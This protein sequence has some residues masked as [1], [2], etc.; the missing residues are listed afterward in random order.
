MFSFLCLFVY[1]EVKKDSRKTSVYA[2][3]KEIKFQV[4]GYFL[5]ISNKVIIIIQCDKDVCFVGLSSNEKMFTTKKIWGIFSTFLERFF[6][7]KEISS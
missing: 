1:K 7:D 6:F 2:K 3:K 4:H 5:F